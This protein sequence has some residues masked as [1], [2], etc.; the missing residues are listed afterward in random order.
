MSD[1]VVTALKSLGMTILDQD[2]SIPL[3]GGASKTADFVL[4]DEDGQQYV[5]RHS[6]TKTARYFQQS[7]FHR[8]NSYLSSICR[9]AD[10]QDCEPMMIIEVKKAFDKGNRKSLSKMFENYGPEGMEWI[11]INAGEAVY[12]SADDETDDV[13]QRSRARWGQSK[14]KSELDFTDL[15]LLLWKTLAY[16]TN[17]LHTVSLGSDNGIHTAME[18][19]EQAGVSYGKANEWIREQK[20]KG[21]VIQ[22]GG[23]YLLENFDWL[24]QLVSTYSMSV[25]PSL[26][27]YKFEEDH[28][29]ILERIREMD[30]E[31]ALAITGPSAI[32]IREDGVYQDVPI[33]A[34]WLSE[35]DYR[36]LMEDL[37]AE[38]LPPHK[39]KE[40]NFYLH[41]PKLKR[42][43]EEMTLE[44]DG[45]ISTD[46][47]QSYL[48][49]VGRKEVEE[50]PAREFI[51]SLS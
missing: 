3:P 19:H 44:V 27:A 40:A 39:G 37:G 41:K 50:E 47:V 23:S 8:E 14:A 43:V 6:E 7:P 29:E 15:D 20:E 36:P 26:D 11:V 12:H 5:A 24:D 34:F 28:Q 25:N 51:D 33:E 46:P 13:Q 10:Y 17:P 4:V 35:D 1:Y 48:D 9:H 42:A 45:L 30:G 21:L 16:S 2:V 22:H 38:R 49:T 32:A 31:D 18:L